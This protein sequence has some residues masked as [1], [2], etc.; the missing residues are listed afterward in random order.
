MGADEWDFNVMTE[1]GPVPVSE[2]DDGN[3][4]TVDNSNSDLDLIEGDG[5]GGDNSDATNE[6]VAD[7]F[8]EEVATGEIDGHAPDSEVNAALGT[9]GD[10]VA[11]AATEEEIEAA[12]G[13]VWDTTATGTGTTGS[14]TATG[15]LTSGSLTGPLGVF[16]AVLLLGIAY[17]QMEVST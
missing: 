9:D 3:Y 1:S 11:V 7:D 8:A 4:E 17:S 2:L 13:V 14:T 16:L 5:I 12:G 15:G 6:S 10:P